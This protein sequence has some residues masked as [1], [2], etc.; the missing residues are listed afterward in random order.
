MNFTLEKLE[1]SQI[2]FFYTASSDEYNET[3]NAV[4]NKTKGKYAIPGFRKGHAPRKVIEGMYGPYV[5]F[6]DAV[7][8]LV[9]KALS[10]LD[11]SKEYDIVS[12][13][14]VDDVDMTEDG[15]V[16][17]TLLVTVKPEVK[18]G[19]YRGMGVEKE[20]EEVT[21]KDV[22]EYIGNQQL[23]QARFIDVDTAAEMGNTVTIDFVGRHDGVEF[24]GGAGTDYDLELGSGTFIPGFEEQ[25]VG[26]KA[27]DVKDVN[28]TFPAEYQAEELAG[29]EAVFACT[30]KAVKKKELPALDDEFAKD[31]SE[32]STFEEY[33]A[34]VRATLEKQAK[35]RSDRAYED[36]IADKLVE[37]SEVEIPD[38]MIERE[39]EDM[40]RDF[41]TRLS[42]QGLKLEQYL[43][44]VQMTKEQLL[45]EYRKTAGERVKI[46]LVMEAVIEKENLQ[47]SDDEI[48]AKIAEI[49]EENSMT[50][51]EYRK[52]L[53]RDEFEYIINS[54]MSAKLI[55]LLRECN[56]APAPEA[57]PAKKPSKKKAAKSEDAKPQDEAASEETPKQ[58]EEAP[59]E[60]APKKKAPA[61][62]TTKK[63][64]PKDGEAE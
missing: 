15:G 37:L 30:V 38:S 17:F 35:E 45:D 26:L 23:K 43:E 33:K 31:I 64:E 11:A 8:E 62:K 7:N 57:A 12:V 9:D 4:Y 41:E 14:N 36:A 20:E 16:K 63:A 59:K 6:S 53:N 32:F 56:E 18:L 22:D 28:V 52:N 29:K 61:K 19:E 27:G 40:V 48:N 3:V 46:R 44:Y 42:Y 2:K 13:D 10:E 1:K 51:E 60:E 39:A 47:I 49:A 24:E 54:V 5:F 58:E 34:D 21:D 25:L 55:A 50:E